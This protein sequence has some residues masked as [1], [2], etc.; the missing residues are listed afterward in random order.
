MP[1]YLNAIFSC[2]NDLL[3]H[4]CIFV[5]VCCSNSD[6]VTCFRLTIFARTLECL[7]WLCYHAASRLECWTWWSTHPAGRPPVNMDI[8]WPGRHRDLAPKIQAFQLPSFFVDLKKLKLC[9]LNP[10][11]YIVFIIQ[12]HNYMGCQKER[13]PV[14][15]KLQ[16]PVMEHQNSSTGSQKSF[17][18]R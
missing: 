18:D 10:C 7:P 11:K 9:F 1:F 8:H 3:F 4:M 2:S 6:N 16:I 17:I 15:M 12:L 14:I 13:N 5:L